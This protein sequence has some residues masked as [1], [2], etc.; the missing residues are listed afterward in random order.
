VRAGFELA[1][2]QDSFSRRP[3]DQAITPLDRI[4]KRVFNSATGMNPLVRMAIN[5]VPGPQQRLISLAGG[6]ADDRIPMQQRITKQ[7]FNALSGIKIQDVDEAWQLQ[8][9]RRQLAGRLSGYMQDYTESYVPKDVL[10]QL[11]RELLPDYML[12]RSLGKQLRE[13]RKARQ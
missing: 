5:T 8:D 11:P 13:T 1:T 6:L 2:G 3:L 10:P 12:F 4:Y 7:L 9:A